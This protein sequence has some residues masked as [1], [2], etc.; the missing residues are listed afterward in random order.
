MTTTKTRPQ[1]IDLNSIQTSITDE[2]AIMDFFKR[3]PT[4]R[5][6][7]TI[8]EFAETVT[9]PA[10][11]LKGNKYSLERTPYLEKPLWYMSPQSNVKRVY[12]M[13]SAQTSKTTCADLAMSYYTK[14]VPS[15]LIYCGKEAG[16]ARKWATKRYMPICRKLGVEFRTSSEDKK[17]RSSGNTTFAKEFD[18]GNMDIVSSMSSSQIASET[19]RVACG[20]EMSRW[21]EDLNGEGFA[22]DLLEAR[23]KQ[24]GDQSK[25]LGVTTPNIEDD[26]FH[27]LYKRGNEE[28][29][30]V[31]CPLGCKSDSYPLEWMEDG[32]D[33]FGYETTAGVI[34]D[35]FY[36]CPTCH[37]AFKESKKPYF[38]KSGIW[39][40]H[41]LTPSDPLTVSMNLN[42]LYSPFEDWLEVA[43]QHALGLEDPVK[44]RSYTN[45]YKGLPYN[46]I[47][48]RPVAEDVM[49][50][51][52]DRIQQGEI[53]NDTLYLSTGGDVQRG[54]EIYQ[55][56]SDEEI[57]KE[58]QAF[59]D[60]GKPLHNKGLPR[61]EILL[62]ATSW[63]WRTHGVTYKV[64]YGQTTDPGSGAFQQFR[65]WIMENKLTFKRLDGTTVYCT[66]VLVDSGDGGRVTTVY[67]FCESFPGGMV[68]PCKGNGAYREGL[69][70]K[71]DERKQ[72]DLT[73]YRE[74]K[75]GI[76]TPLITVSTNLYKSKIYRN[77]NIERIQGTEQKPHF[78]SFADNF[79]PIFFKML[80]A[81]EK[82]ADGSFHAKGRRNEGL[83][84]TVYSMAGAEFWLSKHVEQKSELA[85]KNGFK[86]EDIKKGIT[87]RGCIDKMKADLLKA[88]GKLK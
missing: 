43:K 63:A 83:D 46:E 1:K 70:K 56:M 76:A 8:P 6:S 24:W 30:H 27:M 53:P 19:K 28:H 13:W 51:N 5:K 77:L 72:S 48:T 57:Q 34:T 7:I 40:P 9:I 87:T 73:P 12:L 32:T 64:F 47:G 45:L 55:K 82:W 75:V 18:G 25:F 78:I 49:M 71:G 33:G 67:D 86:K 22:G 21:A 54:K 42:V 52:T 29:F 62:L 38:L 26:I 2:M 10:G 66:I 80:T 4:R 39:T 35:T 85:R 59:K 20:D 23:L 36:I 74:S 37:N 3:R 16:A 50:K 69:E 81:E 44:M 60:L 68:Y 88:Q 61:I 84:I 41:N 58:I 15:E 11:K 14:I 65:E 17:S 31:E 79:P